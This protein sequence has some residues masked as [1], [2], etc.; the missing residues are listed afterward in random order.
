MQFDTKCK[1]HSWGTIIFL[2]YILLYTNT[3]YIIYIDEIY[4]ENYMFKPTNEAAA[5]SMFVAVLVSSCVVSSSGAS[6][7]LVAETQV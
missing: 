6:L 5:L 1:W 3:I 4:R 7:A 2:I